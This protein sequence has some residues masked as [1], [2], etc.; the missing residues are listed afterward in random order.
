MDIPGLPYDFIMWE[1]RQSVPDLVVEKMHQVA[2]IFL[3]D[4]KSCVQILFG[5]GRKVQ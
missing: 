4:S 3:V 5:F 2:R 1:A